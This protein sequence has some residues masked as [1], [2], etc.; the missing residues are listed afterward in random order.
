M[1]DIARSG[2]FVTT[3][4]RLLLA[5]ALAV[6]S[7]ASVVRPATA[8]Q[9]A[10][11][12]QAAQ[13]EVRFMELAID[14]HFMGVMMAQLCEEKAIHEELREQCE[15]IEATQSREIEMLQSWLQDWY[16][17]T[18]EPQMSPGAEQQME[19]LASLSPEEFEIELM[20]MFIRHHWQIIV[21]AAQC[22]DKAYH[23]E[24][25]DLCEDI[26]AVQSAEIELFRTWLCDW[27][28]LCNYGPKG[29]VAGR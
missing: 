25:V 16:G 20:K 18:Y 9:P 4:A 29:N 17:I 21:Q 10:P 11:T 26:I 12:Q 13:F 24:L 23:G 8:D 5:M 27:Y 2:H 14:H 28:D 7:A 6:A 22:T 3:A 1:P 19:R 15:Q